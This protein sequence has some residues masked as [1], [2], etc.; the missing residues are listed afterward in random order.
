MA[1]SY[2][3]V[4]SGRAPLLGRRLLEG[5]DD[6][7]VPRWRHSRTIPFGLPCPA[8][9]GPEEL[10]YYSAWGRT[11]EKPEE[12]GAR[13]QSAP[14]FPLGATREIPDG[15]AYPREEV[16]NGIRYLIEI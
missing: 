2:L 13:Y 7:P 11:R 3:R 4:A 15:I 9:P 14:R 10:N 5:K 8:E 12:I 6:F 1:P 16:Y